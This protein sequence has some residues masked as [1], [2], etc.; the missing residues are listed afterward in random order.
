M[1][2]LIVL[3]VVYVPMSV[4]ALRAE[5]NERA[6]R[7]RGG[8]EAPGDVYAVMRIAYP[9]AFLLMVGEAA[10]RG[11]PWGPL[12]AAGAL[13]FLAGK[14]LKWWAI[15]CLGEAWTFRVITVRR[16]RLVTAGPYRIFRHP[17]YVGVLGELA[18]VGI[19]TG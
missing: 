18:G 14:A 13:I 11:T 16:A 4:E 9:A 5:R 7:A 1:L 15:L 2:I 3:L 19:A 8:V 10:W 12:T 17:N 6:Q